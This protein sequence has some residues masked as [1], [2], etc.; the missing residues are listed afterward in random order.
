LEHINSI[1][2][3]QV[4]ELLDVTSA[5]TLFWNS[6]E[7]KRI[8][9]SSDGTL[10]ILNSDKHI[11]IN[12]LFSL[13]QQ[14][15]VVIDR[16]VSII[17][18]GADNGDYAGLIVPALFNSGADEIN[19]SLINGNVNKLKFAHRFCSALVGK[20]NV[21]SSLLDSFKNVPKQI[22][23]FQ[24]FQQIHLPFRLVIVESPERIYSYLEDRIQ[25]TKK[26]DLM[27]ASFLHLDEQAR[28]NFSSLKFEVIG[29]SSTGLAVFE[30]AVGVN[31]QRILHKQGVNQSEQKIYNTAFTVNAI[32]KLIDEV[33]GRIIQMSLIPTKTDE[34]IPI[35]TIGVILSKK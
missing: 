5:N 15:K 18:E 4:R 30:K 24:A 31:A 27:M 21:S 14:G 12:Q 7:A 10:N 34:E 26:K 29:N 25:R 11:L 33:G 16:K 22:D 19:I 35:R 23:Q 2:N 1:P 20:D 9:L 32:K 6:L 28:S 8:N 3:E 13:I 17:N